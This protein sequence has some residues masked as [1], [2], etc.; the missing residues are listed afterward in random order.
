METPKTQQFK[1]MSH[2]RIVEWH[3]H[4]YNQEAEVNEAVSLG[5]QLLLVQPGEFHSSF[6]LGWTGPET[7]PKTE[8]Q[9]RSAEWLEA[10]Q[11]KMQR[12]ASDR[13]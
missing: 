13:G 3:H 12:Q 9:K 4:N 7:P 6:V 8:Y 1:D 10:A 2:V 5:W 11:R